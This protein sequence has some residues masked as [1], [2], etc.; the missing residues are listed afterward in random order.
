MHTALRVTMLGLA[1]CGLL[2]AASAQAPAATAAGDIRGADV[3]AGLGDPTRWLTFSGDY[4]GARHSPLTQITPRNVRSLA[5]Q[6]TFQTGS[7]ARGRGFETTPLALDGVLYVT[8]SNNTAWALDA[9]TGRPFWEYRRNLPSD[10]TYGAL[11]QIGRA[12]V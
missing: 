12:H 4:T 7:F 3:R 1:L 8:G 11:A 2:K 5:A 9:R 6:W 10:L